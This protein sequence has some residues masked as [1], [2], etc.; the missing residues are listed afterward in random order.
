MNKMIAVVTT[1]VLFVSI[2]SAGKDVVVNP[3][4]PTKTDVLTQKDDVF[5]LT[6][7][8]LDSG[9]FKYIKNKVPTIFNTTAGPTCGCS[10]PHDCCRNTVCVKSCR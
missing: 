3:T 9:S 7:N 1:M 5:G 2:C 6:E 10:G 8:K 4:T